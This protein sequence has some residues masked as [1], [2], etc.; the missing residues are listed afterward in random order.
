MLGSPQ[1]VGTVAVGAAEKRGP[2]FPAMCWVC[3]RPGRPDYAVLVSGT[4]HADG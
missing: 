4:E 2:Q 3:S 1:F